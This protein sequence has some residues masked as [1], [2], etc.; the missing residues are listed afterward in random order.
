MAGKRREFG[1]GR[2]IGG[3]GVGLGGFMC[4]LVEGVYDGI[5]VFG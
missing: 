5:E 1:L 2:L 4:S 3:R